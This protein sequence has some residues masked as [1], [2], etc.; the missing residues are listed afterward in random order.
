MCGVTSGGAV[1]ELVEHTLLKWILPLPVK[2]DEE[3]AWV[4]KLLLVMRALDDQTKHT[5]LVMG[6]FTPYV[7][8]RSR[9]NQVVALLNLPLPSSQDSE[10]LPE[11]SCRLPKIQ[12]E[13]RAGLPSVDREP[14]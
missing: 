7:D 14:C 10:C 6:G 8:D 5:L 3:V 1:R 2:G 9:P 12:R 13:S 4:D 11:L